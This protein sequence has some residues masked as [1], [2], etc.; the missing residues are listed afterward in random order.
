MP[1]SLPDRISRLVALHNTLLVAWS[2]AGEHPRIADILEAM[3]CERKTLYKC[4]E[5]LRRMGAPIEYD[6]KRFT[7]RYTDAWS[8][9]LQVV[10]PV[11]GAFGIRLAMDFLLDPELKD[12]LKNRLALDPILRMPGSTTLARLTGIFPKMYLG[13]LS[14]AIR[15][16]RLVRF[17]YRKPGESS[18]SERI[19]EPV[20][21]FEWNG[22][23]YLQAR[24]PA[25]HPERIKRFTL[26]R[27][28]EL[29]ILERRF[30][31]TPRKQIP[32]CLGAFSG[33]V[34]E[35]VFLA[36]RAHAPYVRERRW[37]PSQRTRE[38]PD[39]SVEFTLPFGDPG[40][41]ARWILGHGPG[42]RPVAPP[43]LVD[44]W[45]RSIQELSDMAGSG[46]VDG[47]RLRS[48]PAAP[49][50]FR[51]ARGKNPTASPPPAGSGPSPRRA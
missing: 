42:Y 15:E 50:G 19:V 16:R 31:R 11:T 3:G 33:D 45:K 24:E 36:D 22:M 8:F 40:E 51:I 30:K 41:A 47:K 46:G 10:E 49:A 35:A 1:A 38:L 14:L 20:D 26:S 12:G 17:D 29:E 39:G 18:S 48:R 9:P 5:E 13:R 37:H 28:H 6:R 43:E 25:K 27:M 23:P 2:E 7:W 32:S 4:A 21:L 34:F 44:A